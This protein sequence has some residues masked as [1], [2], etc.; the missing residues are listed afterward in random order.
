M[1]CIYVYTLA[2]TA[3]MS[4]DILSVNVIHSLL[5]SEVTSPHHCH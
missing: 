3:V 5:V 1:L 4:A 2:V